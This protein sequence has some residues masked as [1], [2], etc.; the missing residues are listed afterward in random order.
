MS[1]S[2]NQNQ[3]VMWNYM[4]LEC[5]VDIAVIAIPSSSSTSHPHCPQCGII[6]SFISSGPFGVRS[7]EDDD[8]EDEEEEQQILD[9]MEA[10]PTV[11]ISS[12]MVRGSSSD[13]SSLLCAICMEDFVV[14]ESARRLPCNHLYH[15]DCIVP[16]L[17]SHNSCPLCRC[18]LQ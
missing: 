6:S 1:S 9:P 17:T 8:S 3:L 11:E 13:E 12:S 5:D 7:A 14:G 4:C 2:S 15:N 16:W 10:I 18:R